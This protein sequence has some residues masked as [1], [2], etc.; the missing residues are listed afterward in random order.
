MSSKRI[1]QRGFTLVEMIVT[2]VT[3]GAMAAVG[4]LLISKLA[5]SFLA[6]SQAEQALSPREAALWRLREDFRK[7]LVDERTGVSLPC[8]LNLYV[9]S[10]VTGTMSEIVTTR[11]VSYVWFSASEQLWVSDAQINSVLLNNIG[12]CPF[13]YA[14][15]VERSRLNLKFDFKADDAIAPVSTT[16]YSYANGPYVL[17]ITPVSGANTSSTAVSMVGVFPGGAGVWT[18]IDFISST[19]VLYSNTPDTGTST[20]AVLYTTTGILNTASGVVD[21]KVTTPEGWSILKQAFTFVS[22]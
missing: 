12:T 14:S 5:P 6:N 8:T 11:P 17:S 13:S 2:I 9:V 7:S 21:V 1:P 19:S 20:S 15:G 4:S 22:Q 16:L 10:D 3:F 18:K